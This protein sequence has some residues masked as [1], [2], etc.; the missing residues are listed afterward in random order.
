MALNGIFYGSTNNQFIKPKIEWSAVQSQEGNYSDVRATLYYSRT[1]W[2]YTTE[3][4]WYG[5]ITID[6][7]V[8]SGSRY[9]SIT[10]DSNTEAISNTVRVHHDSYGQKKLTISATGY[11]YGTSLESTS[12]S[13][14]IELDTIARESTIGASDGFIGSNVTIS[15]K[16]R[17]EA[18]THSIAWSFGALSGYIGPDWQSV[19]EEVQLT[20]TSISFALPEQFYE[21]IPDKQEDLC[22]LVCRTYSGDVQIGAEKL[23]TFRVMA[24][25][26]EC[27]PRV[28]GEVVDINEKT[29]ALT[30]DNT[31]M[32]RGF[33][34]ARCTI[35][36]EA[37]KHARITKTQILGIDVAD[38]GILDIEAFSENQVLF[39]AEDSREYFTEYLHPVELIP[40]VKLSVIAM[41]QRTDPTSGKCTLTVS[42]QFFQGSFGAQDNQLQVECQIGTQDPIILEPELT[43]TG[44]QLAATL[45]GLEYTKS[46][47]VTVIVRDRLMEVPQTM[48][49]KK[50]IPVF[51]WGEKDFAFHVPISVEGKQLWEII[52]PV[53]SIYMSVAETEPSALFGGRWERLK[54]RFLLSAGD[55][56]PAGQTG[57]EAEHVLKTDE[58]P[59]HSHGLNGWAL[60]MNGVAGT[61]TYA[62][63]KPWTE[64]NNFEEN[65][66]QTIQSTGGNLAHNNMPPYLA[67]YMWKRIA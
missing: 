33:S 56:Y 37:L 32:I 34:T 48:T 41:C 16:Q 66:E 42:G 27:A 7:E 39:R 67:V 51:D 9:V 31:V 3:S 19:Q 10:Y 8:L 50:G 11:V 18:Y 29:V 17:N 44:Y 64:Y 20:D 36:A 5:S 55:S 47:K 45:T 4:N 14:E 24:R 38:N 62:L 43:D 59:S 2:G 12:I 13:Q 22:T 61:S 40:Y 65:G 21:Q 28:T 35:S 25:Q 57:G 52:Y 15:V 60:G 26:Q 23:C 53:G 63:A 46:H 30:G 6:G 54:D 49:V 58:L 1:N